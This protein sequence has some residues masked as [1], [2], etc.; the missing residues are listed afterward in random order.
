MDDNQFKQFLDTNPHAVLDKFK[1]E[2]IEIYKNK[3]AFKTISKYLLDKGFFISEATIKSWI[4]INNI[5][6][7]KGDTKI[8]AKKNN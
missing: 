1:D 7:N 8:Y 4:R 2:I 3:A 6:R 5:S